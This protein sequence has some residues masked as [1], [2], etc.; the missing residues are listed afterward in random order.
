MARA[1]RP[2]GDLAN[3]ARKRYYR[4]AERYLRQAENSTGATAARYRS[5]AQKRLNEALNTYTKSTTQNFA[6]PIQNIANKLGVDLNE[7]R[8]KLRSRSAKQEK[9][10][11]SRAIDETRSLYALQG[12]RDSETLRQSEA[13]ALFN[14]PIG[15]RIIGGTVEIWQD[16]ATVTMPDGSTQIDKSKILPALYEYFDVDNL[17]DLLN[18][19]ET[20]SGEDL[21]KSPDDE[22]FY[23]SVKI[24]IQTMI[25]ENEAR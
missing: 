5:M 13:R 10:I 7:A 2:T 3:N 22:A 6:K 20:M 1:K 24:T 4:D 18:A 25:A 12:S 19:I 8:D 21:Y 17:A 9:Q 16:K 14:S 15:S 11:R 23:E